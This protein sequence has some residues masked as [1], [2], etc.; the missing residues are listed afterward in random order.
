MEK[1]IKEVNCKR[2]YE[3]ALTEYTSMLRDRSNPDKL[4]EFSELREIPV[5]ALEKAGIFYIQNMAE[6]MIPKYISMVN[7]FGLI[8]PT[9]KKPIFS[10]RWIIPVKTTNNKV[11]NLVGY[12]N[13][14]DERYIYGKARYYLR[15]DTLFGLENLNV[16]YKLGYA[17]L[18]EGITDT[19][20]LRSLG[21]QNSF[22]MCG[23]HKS[24]KIMT[25]LN[26]C[27]YGI[28]VIPDR[29][30]AGES[31]RKNWV[32]SRYIVLNIYLGYKDVDEMLRDKENENPFRIY[33]E[34]CIRWLKLEEHLGYKHGC[35][36]LTM[37]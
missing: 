37:I 14:A 18:T 1:V 13:T 33:M 24:N 11:Q 20:R 31:A 8:S 19:I 21:I 35:R 16:A 28:V 10:G 25:Q 30:D 36:V 6:I 22:A 4:I 32:T 34:E 3:N 29:D 2:E 9:N 27:R 17:I 5:E 23:T 15:R 7:D 12:S 26:R